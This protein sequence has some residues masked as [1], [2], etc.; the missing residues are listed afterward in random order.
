MNMELNEDEDGELESPLWPPTPGSPYPGKTKKK[1]RKAQK[2]TQKPSLKLEIV[3]QC[4][5]AM[6]EKLIHRPDE[7]A[8]DA[9]EALADALAVKFLPHV[10]SEKRMLDTLMAPPR[11]RPDPAAEAE[12]VVNALGLAVPQTKAAHSI[13]D[14]IKLAIKEDIDVQ[15]KTELSMKRRRI[16]Y[17]QW[18]TQGAVANMAVHYDDWDIDTG[19]RTNRRYKGDDRGARDLGDTQVFEDDYDRLDDL[20]DDISVVT[21]LTRAQTLE[22]GGS[23]IQT[24]T[25]NAN[26]YALIDTRRGGNILS[27]EDT[28][29]K[30][31]AWNDENY[32]ATPKVT[33]PILRITDN[34]PRK[35]GKAA[36]GNEQ[37]ST[38]SL[39]VPSPSLTNHIPNGVH[40]S[41]WK[42]VEEIAAV[43]PNDENRNPWKSIAKPKPIDLSVKPPELMQMKRSYDSQSSMWSLPTVKSPRYDDWSTRM[44]AVPYSSYEDDS[45]LPSVDDMLEETPPP[46]PPKMAASVRVVASAES[47]G[48][49]DEE[50]WET[51]PKKSKMKVK[52]V[53][54]V[55]GR[56]G[57]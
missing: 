19:A 25:S 41:P 30:V 56:R 28:I 16:I 46:S 38:T 57:K 14:K 21:T 47:D 43:A 32:E 7:N 24:P 13:L 48:F 49:V 5:L 3:R 23:E 35:R 52:G 50:G 45:P 40:D 31:Q 26:K 11:E 36:T 6:L 42:P 9:D 17:A 1:D 18:V 27:P 29:E 12:R 53:V 33:T 2:K 55:S 22:D 44:A 39:K 4:D 37:T 51:V 15:W 20:E 8:E 34:I 54:R 10:F